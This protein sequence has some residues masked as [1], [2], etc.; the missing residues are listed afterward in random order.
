MRYRIITDQFGENIM[1]KFLTLAAAAT[2][3]TFAIVPAAVMAETTTAV[4]DVTEAAAAPVQVNAGKMLY[5]ANGFRVAPIYRVTAEG[6]P[7]VI[8]NGKLVTV[9][10]SSL[11]EVDGKVTTALSKKDLASAK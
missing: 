4:R 6:N 5:A 10:A 8:L 3:A 2:V 7:Q 1:K 11:S 9:P